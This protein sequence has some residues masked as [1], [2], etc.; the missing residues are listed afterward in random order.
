VGFIAEERDLRFLY[1]VAKRNNAEVLRI[2][3]AFTIEVSLLDQFIIALQ[4]AAHMYT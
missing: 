3:P 1:R 2:D 4:K